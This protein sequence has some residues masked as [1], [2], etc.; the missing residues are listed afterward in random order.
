MNVKRLLKQYAVYWAPAPPDDTGEQGY[1]PP[2]E[3]RC[4][5]EDKF[6]LIQEPN[7]KQWMT[8]AVV[9]TDRTVS[10]NGGWLWK[11]RYNRL[12]DTADPRKNTDAGRIE[13]YEEIPDIKAKEKGTIRRATL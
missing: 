2:V 7:G 8:K 11:G 5:W 13:R 4:R 6:E 9:L 12:T 1:T 10:A 3:I